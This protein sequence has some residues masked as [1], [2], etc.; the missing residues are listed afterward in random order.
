[1]D[2][3]IVVDEDGDLMDTA[4]SISD[5]VLV[6]KDQADTEIDDGTEAE[7]GLEYFIYKLVKVVTIRTETKAVC[8]SKD[9]Q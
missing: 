5:A 8:T 4:T 1:M 2:K 9:V 7:E 6:A 3:F